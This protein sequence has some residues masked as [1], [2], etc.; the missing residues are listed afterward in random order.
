MSSYYYHNI[1]LDIRPA[2]PI[3]GES[4]IRTEVLPSEYDNLIAP[5]RYRIKGT[6]LSS[7]LND[8]GVLTVD[9]YASNYLKQTKYGVNRNQTIVRYLS[10]G[11]WSDWKLVNETA[12]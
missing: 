7:V 4:F 8:W 5:G 2:H 3:L 11:V 9:T 6:D 10:A 12:Y 1:N